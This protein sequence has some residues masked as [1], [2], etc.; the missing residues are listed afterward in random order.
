MTLAEEQNSHQYTR[1]N[2]IETTYKTFQSL[3]FR[4]ENWVLNDLR[5]PIQ[6]EGFKTCNPEYN[7]SLS[8]SSPVSE[9]GAM[10]V[11]QYNPGDR[12]KLQPSHSHAGKTCFFVRQEWNQF[13]HSHVA[14]VRFENG[15]RCYVLKPEDAKRTRRAANGTEANEDVEV[16][17]PQVVKP[18]G[19]THTPAPERPIARSPRSALRKRVSVSRPFERD[20]AN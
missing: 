1:E 9:T 2:D 19:G 17:A 14:V 11:F 18:A 10:K 20:R 13:R 15:D 5:E 7:R 8:M 6:A 3:N 12:L 16:A 4:S